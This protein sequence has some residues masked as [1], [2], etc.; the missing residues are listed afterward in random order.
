MYRK[1]VKGF[2]GRGI[3]ND[4]FA[5]RGLPGFTDVYSYA[6]AGVGNDVFA[7]R[8]RYDISDVVEGPVFPT[9]F[10][11]VRVRKTASTIDLCL[12]AEADAPSGMG[13][14]PKLNKNGT[15]YALYLV[16]TG[17]ANASPVRIQTSAGTKAIRL[18]T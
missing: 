7:Y 11:G 18:K 17:D 10:F 16:E 2:A 8:Q 5:D 4:V 1:D 9:Q 14:V 15:I 12:V 3:G 13:G 6:A